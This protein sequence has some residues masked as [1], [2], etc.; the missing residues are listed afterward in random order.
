MELTVAHSGLLLEWG[1]PHD[2]MQDSAL[3]W[4]MNGFESAKLKLARAAVHI[5]AARHAIREYL[6]DE[7]SG[8]T[9]DANG[10][11][12]LNFAVSPPAEIA[13]YAGEAL[14]QIR[15][16]LD[17]LAFDLV[18]LNAMQIQLP[19]SWEKRCDFPLLTEI[20]MKGNPPIPCGLPLPYN[21]FERSM[22][23]ISMAAFT[24]IESLQPYHR[25]DGP[26][27]LWYL[28]VLSN[29]DKHRHLNLLNPQADVRFWSTTHGSSV[30]RTENGAEVE[31]PYPKGAKMA[32]GFTPFLSFDEEA[33]GLDKAELTVDHVLQFCLEDVERLVI[34]PFEKFLANT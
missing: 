2:V 9:A 23:G 12:T 34:P 17:H 22:P 31:I 32:G 10:K 4:R 19:A 13:L 27:G 6:A 26:T 28:A 1:S 15:S 33:I 8:I 24:L 14:Y 11:H 29:I 25:G 21:F 20:P 7:P 5:N 3:L 30:I 18:K 16:A